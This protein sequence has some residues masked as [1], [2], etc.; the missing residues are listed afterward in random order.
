MVEQVQILDWVR[1]AFLALDFIP[2][3]TLCCVLFLH[4]FKSIFKNIVP[5]LDHMLQPPVPSIVSPAIDKQGHIDE[6]WV[7]VGV[8]LL[9]VRDGFCAVSYSYAFQ[10]FV[11]VPHEKNLNATVCI[12]T[13]I[14]FV[15]GGGVAVLYQFTHALC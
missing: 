9:A 3:E 8:I 6:H 13:S 10:C 15:G 11:K 4:N 7:V 14:L 1:Q 5:E 2:L 12:I